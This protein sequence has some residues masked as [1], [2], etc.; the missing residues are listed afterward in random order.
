[1]KKRMPSNVFFNKSKMCYVYNKRYQGHRY[2]WTR[3]TLED[4]LLVKKQVEA[5][6]KNDGAIPK[7]L[8]PHADRD[9]IGLLPIGSVVGQWTVLSVFKKQGRYYANCQCSCGKTKDVYCASLTSGQSTNCGHALQ[10]LLVTKDYQ[11]YAHSMQHKRKDPNINNKLGE[12]YI[13]LDKRGRY[14]VSITRYGL[15]VRQYFYNLNEAIKFRDKLLDDIDKNDG[16]IPR[17]YPTK[18]K[19]YRKRP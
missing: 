3:K 10:S 8:D 16:Q 14:Y 15:V 19:S 1:M 12:R 5:S 13:S 17:F 6:L 4:I 7:I 11:N 9:Y 18:E 2:E